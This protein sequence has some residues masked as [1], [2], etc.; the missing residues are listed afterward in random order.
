MAKSEIRES[1][2]DGVLVSA[3]IRYEKMADDA[4]YLSTK[5]VGLDPLDSLDERAIYQFI[6]HDLRRMMAKCRQIKN[7]KKQ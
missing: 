7:A 4:Y 5:M 3:I 1:S 2:V 6:V